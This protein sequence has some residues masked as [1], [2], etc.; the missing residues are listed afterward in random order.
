MNH[1]SIIGVPNVG[2][3]RIGVPNTVEQQITE[4]FVN[5]S[6]NTDALQKLNIEKKNIAINYVADFTGCGYF[7][8]IWPEQAINS[9]HLGPNVQMMLKFALDAGYYKDI[10]CVR[11]QRQVTPEAVNL[12]KWIKMLGE[13]F[14]FKL[15]YDIDDI[16]VAEDIPDYNKHKNSYTN[17]EIR[18]NLIEGMRL[19]DEVTVPSEYMAKYYEEKTG[20]KIN[21]I[22][23]YFPKS[24]FDRYYDEEKLKINLSKYKKQ[25]R[26][27]Y[28]GSASHFDVGQKRVKDDFT[29]ILPLVQKTYKE[30]KWVLFGGYPPELH[31]LVVSGLV[32]YHPFV[33]IGNFAEKFAS[34]N[35]NL[36]IAPLLDNHFNRAKSDIKYIEAGYFGLPGVYQDLD[37]YKEAPFRFNTPDELYSQIKFILSDTNKY[38][39]YCRKTRKN[40]ETRWLESPENLGKFVKLYEFS[41]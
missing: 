4:R 30:F 10:K 16:A 3:P 33:A 25:P 27:L 2:V 37:P 8:M 6:R 14:D 18:K 41:P 1:S 11:V 40:S 15:K 12:L 36:V 5:Q 39:T 21:V 24:M 29:D 22:P 35:C 32:E 28:A 17:P 31:G 9:Q 38:M 23:N 26:I 19:C 20:R 13:K 34:L 7:R